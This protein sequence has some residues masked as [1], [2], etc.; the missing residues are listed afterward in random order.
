MEIFTHYQYP[1][2]GSGFDPAAFC[3]KS[4]Y[5]GLSFIKPELVSFRYQMI[6]WDKDWI[7]VGQRRT[8][9]YSYLRPGAYQFRVSAANSDGVWNA[10]GAVLRV[11]V[12]AA[13]YQTWWFRLLIAAT[14]LGFGWWLYRW[15]VAQLEK[16]SATQEA[17]ARKLIES[18]ESER[19]RLAA[20]LHDGLAQN[21]LVIQ[22]YA[23][24]GQAEALRRHGHRPLRRADQ[25]Q[26]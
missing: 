6:G 5:T 20:E 17:F 7:A 12:R 15:R 3:L 16:L 25:S 19:Q 13:Y 11:V 21:L 2:R 18:Q 26:Q 10:S 8:A 9:Y 24:L 23:V 14:L 4:S 22:N 1:K